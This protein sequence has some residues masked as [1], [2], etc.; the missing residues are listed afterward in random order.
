MRQQ[1]H[2]GALQREDAPALEEVAVVADRGADGAEAEVV[3][4]PLVGLAE[5]EELVV[6]GVHL[7]LEPDQAV[8]AD[9]RRRVVVRAAEALAEAVGDDD[10]ARPS[11]AAWIVSK[12][13]PSCG[14][15]NRVTSWLPLFPV[16]EVSGKTTRSQPASAV[17]AISCRWISRLC[18]T[19]VWRT[20][21]CVAATVN[22]LTSIE[23]RAVDLV[24]DPDEAVALGARRDRAHDADDP[25]RLAEDHLGRAVGALEEVQLPDRLV[26]LDPLAEVDEDL[27]V[28]RTPARP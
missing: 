2:L 15:A 14:S 21:T 27:E 24:R 19:S 5:A 7:A 23:L 28:A 10:P 9:E 22:G 3:D 13:R 20:S 4:A 11:P 6:G 12:I 25:R 8:R 26:D 1:D 16:A 18:S 17:S